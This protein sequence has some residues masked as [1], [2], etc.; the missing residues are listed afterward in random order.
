MET[1]CRQNVDALESIT[2]GQAIMVPSI[3]ASGIV[4]RPHFHLERVAKSLSFQRRC[5]PLPKC[6]LICHSRLCLEE[7]MALGTIA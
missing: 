2:D 5:S 3:S 7:V 1:L 6:Q 4:D